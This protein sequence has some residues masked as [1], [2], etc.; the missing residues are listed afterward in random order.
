VHR[1]DPFQD[2]LWRQ[3]LILSSLLAKNDWALFLLLCAGAALHFRRYRVPENDYSSQAHLT[4]A[5]LLGIG[6]FC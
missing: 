2:E 6:F 3:E 5:L 1:H 4:P